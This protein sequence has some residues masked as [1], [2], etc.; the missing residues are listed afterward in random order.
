MGSQHK[1]QISV[2]FYLTEQVLDHSTGN[3]AQGAQRPPTQCTMPG[4]PLE[5]LS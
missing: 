3:P 1:P 2:Q 5:L 4:H